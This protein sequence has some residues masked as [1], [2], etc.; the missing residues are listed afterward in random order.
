MRTIDVI[1]PTLRPGESFEK[2]LKRLLLQRVPVRRVLVANTEESGWDA[3][4]F[5]PLFEGAGTELS[6]WH[7]SRAEF[8]HGRTRHEAILR[9]DA[10]MVVC[11]T[12]DCIPYDRDLIGNLEKAL[13]AAP[14][15]AAAYA[16]QLPAADCS[17]LERLTRQFNYPPAG[18]VK[19]K[20][21]LD[22]LG[23]KTF[24]C[25]NVCAAYKR[26]L[27][28]E[29]G[30]FIRRTIFNE[31]MIFAARAV[32]AGYRIAYA[33]NAQVI[34]SHNYTPAQQIRRNFDL[35]VSQADHPEIFQAVSSEG[36]GL[37]LVKETAARLWSSGRAAQIPRLIV[38]SGCKYAGY[39]LG[40]HYKR[41]PRPLV[42]ALTMNRAYWE[43]NGAKREDEMRDKEKRA[44]AQADGGRDG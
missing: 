19:G 4:R 3:A 14:D 18:R 31:D 2:L 26:D 25:S 13:Y 5:A 42:L 40:K 41:L 44:A 8:D 6:V 39:V 11:M 30:G 20:A 15:I 22:E 12:Q 43:E 17:A 29:L 34:H 36:E 28:L 23:I 32:E 16:R 33:A 9:S 27:Y 10:D 38:Q 37:R 24:F 7:L 1:I 21:D 35:A